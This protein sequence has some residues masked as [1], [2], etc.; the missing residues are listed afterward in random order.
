MGQF[1]KNL[2]LSFWRWGGRGKEEKKLKG[3]EKKMVNLH[4]QFRGVIA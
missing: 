1:G 2:E 3:E 4:W